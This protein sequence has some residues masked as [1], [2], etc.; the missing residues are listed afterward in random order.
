MTCAHCVEAVTREVQAVD[1]VA[2]V[3]VDLDSGRLTVRGADVAAADVRDA[4]AE[5]G[6]PLV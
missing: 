6:Y 1:G 5:A 3:I 2:E 4:V